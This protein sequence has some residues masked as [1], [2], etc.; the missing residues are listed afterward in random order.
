MYIHRELFVPAGTYKQVM[1]NRSLS[2]FLS[3]ILRHNPAAAGISLDEHGW[4]DIDDLLAALHRQGRRTTQADLEEVVR[5]NNK[6]RFALDLERRRIR[7]HQGHSIP[8]DP[9][10]PQATPPEFLYHGTAQ[11]ALDAIRREGLR[12][13][14]RLHVHL[15]A[16][17]EV[18]FQVARRRGRHIILTVRAGELHRSGHVFYLSPNGVWLT[19][20]VPVGAIYFP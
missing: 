6:Q 10:L 14:T 7:A 16:D 4:A 5:T 8:I 13:M 2:K 11:Q 19:D 3:L 17:R 12:P 1:K 9:D 20:A 15:A 18:A